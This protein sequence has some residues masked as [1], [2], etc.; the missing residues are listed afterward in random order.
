MIATGAVLREHKVV[1]GL[2][3]SGDLSSHF[4]E[5]G[6]TL[7]AQP[8]CIEG[9]HL[10]DETVAVFHRE[11]GQD[12]TV[13]DHEGAVVRYLC[14][15]VGHFSVQV[16]GHQ[17]RRILGNQSRRCTESISALVMLG[18]DQCF[19]PVEAVDIG[20]IDRVKVHST[21]PDHIWQS[22]RNVK[23]SSQVAVED[24]GARAVLRVDLVKGAG[25]VVPV[26]VA[27]GVETQPS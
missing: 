15:K 12:A 17:Q 21:P 13:E 11:V 23:R 24:D 18:P 20:D 4:W 14:R 5:H 19:E 9:G 1:M 25:R 2:D 3:L 16:T 26:A 27:I 10:V 6:Y 8:N 22:G 7:I